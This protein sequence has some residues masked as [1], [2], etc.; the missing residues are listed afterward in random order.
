[1]LDYLR[2]FIDWL[3]SFLFVWLFLSIAF[4]YYAYTVE[5]PRKLKF[6]FTEKDKKS[7]LRWNI[8]LFSVREGR[9]VMVLSFV[10]AIIF[11][12]FFLISFSQFF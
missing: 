5:V 1:M 6:P 4:F 12:M 7:K 2:L 10:L 8:I 9:G 3:Y 11:G